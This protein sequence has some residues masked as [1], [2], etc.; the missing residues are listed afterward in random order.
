MTSPYNLKNVRSLLTE[1][2]T[3]EELRTF[4]FDDP[5][6]RPVYHGLA[7][8]TG[9]TQIVYRLLEYADQKELFE[10]LLSWAKTQNPAKY[11]THHPYRSPPPISEQ[12]EIEHSIALQTDR[13]PAQVS[14]KEGAATIYYPCFISY[15]HQDEDFAQKLHADLKSKGVRCWFALQDMRIGDKIRPTID[16]SIQAHDKL[17]LILSEHSINS[18][19][20]GAEVETALEKENKLK[21][22]VLFPIRLDR[23]VMDTD[24]AW[25]AHIRRTRHIGDFS[26][27]K[28]HDAYQQAFERLLRDLQMEEG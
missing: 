21:Q 19:W 24:Q 15:S 1:G 26:H 9:K 27:W 12:V 14:M 5:Q 20:V 4:C 22:P 3:T 13:D 6:F 2:F 10:V 28:D 7:E 18:D 16:R 25:A 8:G 11:Q 23:A 17:L